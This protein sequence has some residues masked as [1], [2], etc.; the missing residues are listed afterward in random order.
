MAKQRL[1]GSLLVGP[2]VA[3]CFM[4][5]GGI[6]DLFARLSSS[7]VSQEEVKI[8]PSLAIQNG[9]ARLLSPRVVTRGRLNSASRKE[10]AYAHLCSVHVI[11]SR[12]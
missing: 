7:P 11:S 5:G 6:F 1:N 8:R 4:H 2:L 9:F 12:H 3:K 10:C